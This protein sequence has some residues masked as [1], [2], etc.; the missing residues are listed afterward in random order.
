LLS[1][2]TL[3]QMLAILESKSRI[4]AGQLARVLATLG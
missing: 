3:R 2:V 1:A 4:S